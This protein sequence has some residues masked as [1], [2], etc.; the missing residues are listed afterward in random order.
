MV[1]PINLCAFGG[2]SAVKAGIREILRI[3]TKRKEVN[4]YGSS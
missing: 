3:H 1:R 2:K 4:I